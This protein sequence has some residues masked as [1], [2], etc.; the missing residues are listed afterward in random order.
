ML[1]FS[2]LSSLFLLPANLS[3]A[4]T[5]T[6]NSLDQTVIQNAINAASDGDTIVLPPGSATWTTLTANTPAIKISNKS[7]SLIGSGQGITNITN[8][9]NT[10]WEEN[11][12][13]IK[14]TQNKPFR[15]SGMTITQSAS[16]I[17]DG[18][19]FFE[20]NNSGSTKVK[21]FRVDHI[22]FN[23]TDG[24]VF[25]VFGLAYGV[26]DNCTF[27][28]N[29]ATNCHAFSLTGK[30][31]EDTL[32][33]DISWSNALSL[34]SDDA[35]YIE[36]C[37]F[38]YTNDHGLILDADE[39]ARVV[40][41]YNTATNA[42]IGTHGHDGSYQ[43][44]GVLSYEI[45]ENIFIANATTLYTAIALRGGTGVIYKNTLTT[46]NGG[47]FNAGIILYNYCTCPNVFDC[48]AWPECINYPC[49]DQ[50]G[51]G[52]TGGGGESSYP[53]YIWENNYAGIELSGRVYVNDTNCSEISE[54]IKENRD[55]YNNIQMSGY[56]PYTYPH[57]LRGTN[58]GAT[59]INTVGGL[60]AIDIVGGLNVINQ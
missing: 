29:P 51:W 48:S 40:F 13:L 23:Y 34:G 43:H 18:I 6:L 46:A 28:A 49:P 12:I 42:R 41:R 3:F 58:K 56:T 4:A 45:Y 27:N 25:K 21:G 7:I 57:P 1:I 17:T 60:N 22:T 2:L 50:V 37:T 44:R 30:T 8:N 53:L 9:T 33:G 31:S 14:N 19:L 54:I 47:V 15:I 24:G 32:S 39:G 35:F 26:V 16:K 36:N 52:P 38:N 59:I 20:M 55:Y 10:G 11:A 5:T